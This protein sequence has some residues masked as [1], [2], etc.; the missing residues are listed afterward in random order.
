MSSRGEPDPTLSGRDRTKAEGRAALAGGALLTALSR[1][2]A[3][4]SQIAIFVAAARIL[5][6]VEFGFFALVS[7]FA[8][9][10]LKISEAGWAEYIMAWSGSAD[11]VKKVCGIAWISGLLMMV[12]GLVSAGLIPLI[13]EHS[14]T[15]LL[16][17]GFAIWIFLAT[18]SAALNGVMI[19][20]GRIV[21]FALSG[22]AAETVGLIVTLMLL[23]AGYGVLALVGGRL[24]LQIVFLI[25]ALLV[26]RIAPS[27]KIAHYE[28]PDLM[29][30]TVNILAS[31]LI[32][33]L[34]SYAAVFIV[35]GF[36]GPAAV[37][38]FRAG[39]RV[40]GAFSELV[41]EPTRVLAWRTFRTARDSKRE[42]A[43]QESA[44]VF[45]P[46]LGI[47]AI[48]GYLWISLFAEPMIVG[49]LGAEW[50]PAAPVIVLLSLAALLG[51]M[52]YATEPLMSLTGNTR[53]LPRLFLSYAVIGILMT[54]ATGPWGMIAVSAAQV[55]VAVIILAVNVW[56]YQTRLGISIVPVIRN[57]VPALIPLTVSFAALYFLDTLDLFTGANPLV[58]AL[59][60]SLPTIVIYGGLLAVFYRASLA[61]LR[62]TSE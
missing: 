30:F 16:V 40:V 33:V 58:R 25:V 7:A 31:R 48:P 15:Q 21:S 44:N 3:Q 37:G 39:Q 29:N 42:E 55:V 51:T 23:R 10:A 45:F 54:I 49:L 43:L 9:I 41:G 34:R 52:G 11:G 27:L 35:A 19:W 5:G 46:V 26:T 22:I 24:A 13:T 1:A 20:Q 62:H 50:A 59:L 61:K 36:F 6:P 2:Y 32:V 56:V 60:I 38:F 18:P 14:D 12:V 28:L 4:L 57:L 8:F 47:I 17:A 53:I